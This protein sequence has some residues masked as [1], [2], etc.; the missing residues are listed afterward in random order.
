ML[1][2]LKTLTAVTSRM[3]GGQ[4]GFRLSSIGTF[5][6]LPNLRFVRGVACFEPEDDLFTDFDCPTRTSTVREIRLLRSAIC[7]LG[8][9]QMITACKTLDKF[10]CD[11]AGISLGW[12]E[13]NFPLLTLA[14]LNHKSTLTSIGLNTAKH[15]DSWPERDNGLV[16]PFGPSLREFEKLITLDVPASCLIG[17]DEDDVG[18]YAPLKDVLP[19]NIEELSINEF[20]PRLMELLDD[21][22]M[23]CAE[24]YPK[25]K[26][27]TVS[28]L[29]S[30]NIKVEDKFSKKFAVLA[31]EVKLSFVD[32]KEVDHFDESID[33]ST[34]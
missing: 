2:S 23:V 22:A 8:L 3:E 14:L 5:F 12:V 19:P 31:P 6:V 32:G 1:R 26:K 18:G 7:P 24:R 15:Y 27:L 9:R 29:F 30:G 17:W 10:T 11:W 25:L 20:A 4:G 13:I 16:P 33:E 28:R 21:F 34:P